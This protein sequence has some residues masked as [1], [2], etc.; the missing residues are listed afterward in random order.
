MAAV[1]TAVSRYAGQ[2]KY[3]YETEL[4]A[5]PDLAGVVELRWSLGNG[6]ARDVR[7]VRDGVGSD[8]LVRCLV[9]KVS[10]WEFPAG[11]TGTVDWPFRFR[12]EPG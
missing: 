5:D 10:K 3:C 6:A 8:A 11:L 7:L 2:A 12:P 1:R 4:R 9:G